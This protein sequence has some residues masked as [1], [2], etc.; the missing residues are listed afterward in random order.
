MA[1][2]VP[3]VDGMM[4]EGPISGQNGGKWSLRQTVDALVDHGRIPTGQNHEGF[5]MCG[6]SPLLHVLHLLIGYYQ[7][8]YSPEAILV[9]DRGQY[10]IIVQGY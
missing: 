7:S 10:G 9:T 6:V 8:L 3:V 4:D 2:M 5:H 1:P